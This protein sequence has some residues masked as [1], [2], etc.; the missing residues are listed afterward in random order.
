[1]AGGDAARSPSGPPQTEVSRLSTAEL[2][3]DVAGDVQMLVRKELELARIELT[4][5]IR[6]QLV[7]AGLIGA[8]V[9]ALL[10]GLLFLVVALAIWLPVS[11]AAGFAIV[12]GAMLL[13][14]GVGVVVGVS[15]MKSQRPTVRRTA[16]SVRDDVRMARSHIG[17]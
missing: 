2:I 14:T 5:G 4:E 3:A 11:T 7:G 9:L 6:A 12:G 8:A 16:A 13:F 1:M 15:K 17:S 10:P